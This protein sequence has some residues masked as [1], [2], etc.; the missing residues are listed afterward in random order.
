MFSSRIS[1]L[2]FSHFLSGFD[3]PILAITPVLAIPLCSFVSFVGLSF[4]C[5]G[6]IAI[7]RNGLPEPFTIL[8]GAAITTAP[9]GGN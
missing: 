7:T 9:V 2:V 5:Y 1:D 6:V 8:S 4:S 3:F